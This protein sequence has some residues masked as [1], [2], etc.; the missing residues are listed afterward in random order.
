MKIEPS[1]GD[2]RTLISVI[3]PAYRTSSCLAELHSRVAAV[4]EKA[5]VDFELLLVNDASPHD[6]W[7]VISE[8]AR[9]DPRVKGIDLTR[10]FGQ[11]YAI[12]AGIDHAQ[13]DWIV[14]MD[15]DLQDRPEEI[16]RLYEKA[17]E[18]YEVVFALRGERHD[19]FLKR[20][21]SRLFNRFFNL[22]APFPVP[23]RTSNFSI[24]SR[25]VANELRA[26]RERARSYGLLVLWLGFPAGFVE[27][28]HAD[29]FSGTTS[30]SFLRSLRFAIDSLVSQ[31]DQ[32]LRMSIKLGF[33]TSALSALYAVWLAIRF[34][35]FGVAV[36]GWTSV[37]VS[38]FFLCGILL[39]DLGV[40]GLYLGKLFDESKRR[41]LY[42]VRRKENL[43]SSGRP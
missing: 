22:L 35:W 12:A 9:R 11:H 38:L 27:V 4:L 8:L 37:M 29:R 32:P 31:S 5:G 13:G 33:A 7:K 16:P 24:I 41:P 39:A 17:L 2:A 19:P 42:V 3:A 34:Y 25:V 10:N 20:L 28:E 14:V 36:A 18:G 26:L 1:S 43:E 6:D 23:A 40:L 30:Y 15:A 21:Y